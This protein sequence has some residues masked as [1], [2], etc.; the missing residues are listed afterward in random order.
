[1]ILVLFYL[2][3]SCAL[4]YLGDSQPGVREQSQGNSKV[5]NFSIFLDLGVHKYQTVEKPLLC[6]IWIIYVCFI[7]CFNVQRWWTIRTFQNKNKKL[8]KIWNS[9]QTSSLINFLRGVKKAYFI[10]LLMFKKNE[11]KN[12]GRVILSWNLME[13]IEP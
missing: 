9:L 2:L 6:L 13:L 5:Y 8:Q 10:E 3:L 11:L 1:M 4:L 12:R 7:I